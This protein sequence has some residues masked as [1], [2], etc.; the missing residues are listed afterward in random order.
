MKQE[1]K[2]RSKN[3][4]YRFYVKW[5]PRI[6]SESK[7]NF[8]VSF[9]LLRNSNSKTSWI[10]SHDPPTPEKC[11]IHR[12]IYITMIAS[13]PGQRMPIIYDLNCILSEIHWLS[14]KLN[15]IPNCILRFIFL[16][17]WNIALCNCKFIFDKTN[18]KFQ[19]YF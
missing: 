19:F 17:L 15:A 10:S 11:F 14:I 7:V 5:I 18:I 12:T 2:N 13:F 16:I 3:I 9:Q 4:A 8:V 1:Q 6:H